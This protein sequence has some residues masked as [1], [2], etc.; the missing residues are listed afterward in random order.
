[1]WAAAALV[2]AQ[3]RDPVHVGHTHIA[4]DQIERLGAGALER[5]GGASLGDR[6]VARVAEQ[7][8]QGLAQARLVVD[9][10]HSLHRCWSA[11][12][13]NI[14]NAAPPSR[15]VSTHTTPPMSS[16]A[17]ATMA[18]PSPVPRPGALVV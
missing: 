3:E 4:Q 12:G 18:R 16:T 2:G 8:A 6:V 5:P 14:L 13:K 7:Q 11:R 10:Q 15:A 1:R 17:R 9:H